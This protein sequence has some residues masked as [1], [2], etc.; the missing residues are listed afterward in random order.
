MRIL[1]FSFSFLIASFPIFITVWIDRPYLA[2]I[3]TIESYRV[4][5]REIL[6]LSFAVSAFAI[7]ESASGSLGATL[8][9][10]IQ[11]GRIVIMFVF[12]V[13]MAFTMIR[14]GRIAASSHDQLRAEDDLQVWLSWTSACLSG[15]GAAC[16]KVIG[17]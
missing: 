16:L 8:P 6:F 3:F 4:A 7:L 2:A 17:G 5:M 13:V 1:L 9:D 15:I 12:I 14:Y 11:A 10:W